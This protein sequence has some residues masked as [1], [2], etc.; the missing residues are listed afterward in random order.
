MFG[1]NK[2]VEAKGVE[3]DEILA[4]APDLPPM[5][6]QEAPPPPA[7][8]TPARAAPAAAEAVSSIS[9][10]MTIV[11]KLMGDGA[12]RI[13]GRMEGELQATSVVIAEGGSVEGN[14]VAQ[15][16]TV[17]GRVKGTVHA[18]RVKLASTAVVEGDIF[19]RSLVIEESA[20]FEGSS[21]RED[22]VVEKPPVLH[23]RSVP[24]QP[25]VKPVAAPIEIERKI[26]PSEELQQ[27]VT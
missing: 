24:P 1:R 4:P 14:I 17:G 21:R 25:V 10:G 5:P 9:A 26:A 7:R 12:V 8:P 6:T 11:G 23:V 13:L 3:D 27:S 15:D 18:N 2:A 22:N 19:H 20:R 16:L